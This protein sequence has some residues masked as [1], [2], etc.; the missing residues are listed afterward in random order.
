MDWKT[1]PGSVLPFQTGP[2]GT[3]DSS[4]L[5]AWHPQQPPAQLAMARTAALPGAVASL[6][7]LQEVGRGVPAASWPGTADGAPLQAQRSA[8]FGSGIPALPPAQTDGE[9]AQLHLL[10]LF[11]H[12]GELLRPTR[13]W[14]AGVHTPNANIWAGVAVSPVGETL[15]FSSRPGKGGAPQQLLGFP[16]LETPNVMLRSLHE[17]LQK[18]HFGHPHF[19]PGLVWLPG[20]YPKVLAAEICISPTGLPLKPFPLICGCFTSAPPAVTAALQGPAVVCREQPVPINP[21]LLS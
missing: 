17:L 11:G 3:Q 7:V 15:C 6:P 2:R 20:Q 13:I 8:P 9:R 10:G 16:H 4:L 14:L 21:W 12:Y 19:L 5:S 18:L 1:G